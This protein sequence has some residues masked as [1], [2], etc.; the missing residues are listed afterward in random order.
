ML[1]YGD[2]IQLREGPSSYM[3]AVKF[4]SEVHANFIKE[5]LKYYSDIDYCKWIKT[6]ATYNTPV[7]KMSSRTPGDNSYSM[8]EPSTKFRGQ[9]LDAQIT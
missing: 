9:L 6:K 8:Q 2:I 5:T 3:K 4:T 7:K 1:S